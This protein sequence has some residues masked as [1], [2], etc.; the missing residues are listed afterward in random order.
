MARVGAAPFGLLLG[1]KSGVGWLTVV[2]SSERVRRWAVA[3]VLAHRRLPKD[4]GREERWSK[5]VL[6][7]WRGWGLVQFILPQRWKSTLKI[8]KE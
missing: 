6:K 1:W 2:G 4:E 7:S 5:K 3:V 8:F